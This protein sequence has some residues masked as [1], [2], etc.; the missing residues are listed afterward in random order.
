MVFYVCYLLRWAKEKTKA[1]VEAVGS[2]VLEAAKKVKAKAKARG[3]GDGSAVAMATPKKRGRPTKAKATEKA[4]ATQTMAEAKKKVKATGAVAR[5]AIMANMKVKRAKGRAT[6]KAKPD[7]GQQLEVENCVKVDEL[8]STRGRKKAKAKQRVKRV[9]KQV[10]AVKAKAKAKAVAV[11]KATADA[12]ASQKLEDAILDGMVAEDG[13]DSDSNGFPG[14]AG[15]DGEVF[16]DSDDDLFLDDDHNIEDFD[17]VDLDPPL[18][19]AV[20]QMILQLDSG[21]AR[22]WWR[23][24]R[25]SAFCRSAHRYAQAADA[26]AAT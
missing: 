21:R 9:S 3:E 25:H 23:I 16:P 5:M 24:G 7:P 17:S 19:D 26:L 15:N 14:L 20:R 13:D 8:Q 2:A 11:A 22:L 18:L 1:A 4:E 12:R 6:A 10:A